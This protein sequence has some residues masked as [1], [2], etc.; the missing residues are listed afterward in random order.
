M[1]SG[2]VVPRVPMSLE[3]ECGFFSSATPCSGVQIDGIMLVSSA[4]ALARASFKAKGVTF[5][6]PCITS[7]VRKLTTVQT[8]TERV[9]ELLS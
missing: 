2:A 9:S 5:S 8:P 4:G 6:P 1:K 3:T 7:L